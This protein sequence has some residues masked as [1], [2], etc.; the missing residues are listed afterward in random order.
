M[1]FE[2][3]SPIQVIAHDI[4]IQ[5][6]NGI[7]KAV[8]NY[9]IS[10]DKDELIKALKYDREQ[11][12]QGYAKGRADAIAET[13]EIVR[14]FECQFFKSANVP[15]GYGECKLTQPPIRYPVKE[16]DYCSWGKRRCDL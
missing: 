15:W 4:G 16:D 14:C 5:I 11:Y 7:Y 12:D 9:G 10:V 2:Y 1:M 13:A 8:Q 3:E 6:E